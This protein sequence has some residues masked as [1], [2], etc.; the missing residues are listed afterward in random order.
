MTLL[1]RL[2]PDRL[3]TTA[4]EFAI[5]FPVVL[6]ITLGSIELALIMLADASLEIAASEASR[7]G[8]LTAYGDAAAREAKVKSIVATIAGRWIPVKSNIT[9]TTRIYPDL[10][11]LGKPTWIESNG[12][13]GCQPAEGNCAGVQVIPGLGHSGDLVVYTI[14]MER[15]GFTGILKTVGIS[16]LAFQRKIIVINE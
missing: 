10:T 12:I 11:A 5:A 6:L 8:A 9:V 4:L 1:R 13:P 2:V 16:N 15:S 3:G 7:I 14:L